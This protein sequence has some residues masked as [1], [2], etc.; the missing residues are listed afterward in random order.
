MLADEVFLVNSL[1]GV[2]PVRDIEGVTYSV[3]PLT[4]AAQDWLKQEDDAQTA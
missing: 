3:G 2:W 4:R 1:I